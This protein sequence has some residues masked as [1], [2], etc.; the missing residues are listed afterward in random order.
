M[1]QKKVRDFYEASK[2]G[3]LSERI[4]ALKRLD[5]VLKLPLKQSRVLEIGCGSGAI[6]LPVAKRAKSTVGM[7][8]SRNCIEMAKLHSKEENVLVD[9]IVADAHH[10]PFKDSC[11]DIVLLPDVI[12]HLP[13][14][15]IDLVPKEMY[16]V[17]SQNG[18]AYV[19]TLW[20][21]NP[22][23]QDFFFGIIRKI[24]TTKDR[25]I[26][27]SSV[28]HAHLY[29]LQELKHLFS[30]VGFKMESWQATCLAMEICVMFHKGVRKSHH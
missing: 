25:L 28:T 9:L 4:Y 8:V 29:T 11:F 20:G 10:L 23:T 14:S 5:P 27:E 16:R 2:W 21:S 30:K 7:D 19:N 18:V 26:E 15:R 13:M 3:K 1:S 6:L 17:L 24:F 12:E 22:L